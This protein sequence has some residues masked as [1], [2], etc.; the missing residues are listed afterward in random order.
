MSAS[1]VFDTPDLITKILNHRTDIMVER[2][3]ETEEKHIEKCSKIYPKWG[4]LS[5]WGSPTRTDPYATR[6]AWVMIYNNKKYFIYVWDRAK[7]NTS[8]INYQNYQHPD[9]I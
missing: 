1:R 4:D 6:R 5:L 3:K 7:I 2:R 8:G 9:C